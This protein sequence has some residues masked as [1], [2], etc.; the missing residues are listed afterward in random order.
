MRVARG[1]ERT[2]AP[3]VHGQDHLQSGQDR[4][5]GCYLGR[6]G[7]RVELN[8]AGA[9]LTAERRDARGGGVIGDDRCRDEWRQ[10]LD[11]R[12]RPRLVEP[13]VGPAGKAEGEADRVGTRL[14]HRQRVLRGRDASDLHPHARSL[15]VAARPSYGRLKTAAW[16]FQW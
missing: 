11:D 3:D 5:H 7:T 16:S 13:V 14:L 9:C 2:L 4:T 1:L 8:G 12:P 10:D 6:L 15:P